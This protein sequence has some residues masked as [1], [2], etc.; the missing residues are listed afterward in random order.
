MIEPLNI[1]RRICW[2]MPA[3]DNGAHPSCHRRAYV[4]RSLREC[5]VPSWC[6]GLLLLV[7]GRHTRS[8]SLTILAV[9]F[10]LVVSVVVAA[11]PSR[12]P[13]W[14]LTVRL[15]TDKLQSCNKFCTN[16]P[17]TTTRS[18]TRSNLRL[19]SRLKQRQVIGDFLDGS[20]NRSIAFQIHIT[21]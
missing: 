3:L 4:K 9:T 5:S 15:P 21:V 1:Q 20:M 19:C 10:W 11:F 6:G 16:Q 12:F 18:I 13:E 2:L 17:L 8:E 14:T 7:G